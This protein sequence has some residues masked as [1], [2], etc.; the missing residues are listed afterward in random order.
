MCSATP[1]IVPTVGWMAQKRRWAAESRLADAVPAAGQLRQGRALPPHRDPRVSLPTAL[2]Q[3]ISSPKGI[4]GE[5]LATSRD[6]PGRG[7]QRSV[8][9][10]DPLRLV[11]AGPVPLREPNRVS[12]SRGLRPGQ[13][14]TRGEPGPK[15]SGCWRRGGN[16][17]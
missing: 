8:D 17:R 11:L 2:H 7:D 6:A 9:C 3:P 16:L 4:A 1:T 10:S 14:H 13:L 15:V 12:R 5:P